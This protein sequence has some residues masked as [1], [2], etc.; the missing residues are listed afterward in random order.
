ME[1]THIKRL[2]IPAIGQTFSR[3]L[4]P[5]L[6]DHTQEFLAFLDS[7]N[8]PHEKRP[9][10]DCCK[11]KATQADGFD[12]SKI[13]S[14]PEGDHEIII[15]NDLHVIDGHHRWL[16]A[17]NREN[18][19]L[20]AHCIDL[21]ILDAV[22][23]AKEF[24]ASRESVSEGITRKE[25]QPM[26]DSFV[27]FA[28]S[29]LGIKSL[30]N[31]EYK[32]SDERA[33]QPS[34]GGYSPSSKTITVSTKGRHPMDIFR[35]IAH[36]LVH[37]KQD[38]DGEL[39]DIEKDGAT[40]SDKENHANSM[41]GILMRKHAKNFPK[42]FNSNNL[43]EE[44][45]KE[46]DIPSKREWG[47]PSL[48]KKYKKETPGQKEV[49]EDIAGSTLTIPN[50][51]GIGPEVRVGKGPGG[52][53]GAY[54]ASIAE[55]IEEWASKKET[56]EKFTERYGKKAEAK[57]KE[58][59]NKLSSNLKNI[60]KLKTGTKELNESFDKGIGLMGT[61]S[62]QGNE[63]IGEDK[64]GLWDNIH[65]RRRSGKKMRK[66]GEKGAPTD[67]QIKAAQG[68]EE[69]SAAWQRKEGKNPEGGLNKKGIA[70]YRKQ[71][72]G[73]K[74]SMAVTTEPSKLKKGSKSWKR[75]K[76]FCARMS[77][78]SGPMKDDKGK[79]TRKALALKK[80]NCE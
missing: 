40:G 67:A 70:S 59:T 1:E 14:I 53:G 79:P 73:S 29:E 41:A 15:S 31:I 36:E 24:L 48:T 30:P 64:P 3:E 50:S 4:M 13:M 60:K 26:V 75:R 78:V 23:K 63:E 22:A 28:S 77:G 72:P 2:E 71:N 69:E 52:L 46:F 17:H 8:I 20:C 51:D 76:S 11:L 43:D 45:E 16:A 38:E 58:A 19:N 57:L 37:S 74:L 54:T 65:A 33:D 21:P 39:T 27:D 42:L 62:K 35:T 5:Q 68:I 32:N 66:K 34:F 56:K 18:I 25:F 55:S 80:W 9:D 61:V 12:Y 6:G 44:F 10:I 47:T 49:E 7:Q